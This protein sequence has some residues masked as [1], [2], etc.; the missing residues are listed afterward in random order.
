MIDAGNT[1]NVNETWRLMRGGPCPENYVDINYNDSPTDGIIM[2]MNSKFI[3]IAWKPFLCE[4]GCAVVL[5]AKA[6]KGNVAVRTKNEV[7][8]YYGH[9]SKVT[10]V[11]LCPLNENIMATCSEDKTVRIWEIPDGG[12]Q[13]DQQESKFTYKGH[14]KKTTQCE[15]HP[16]CGEVIASA[17]LDKTVHVWN[18]KTGE[19]ICNV[20]INEQPFGLSWNSNGSLL[21]ACGKQKAYVIDPR[22]GQIIATTKPFEAQANARVTFISE[23]SFI[24][25]AGNKN[26][27][28]D[29]ILYDVRQAAG[30]EIPEKSKSKKN[31]KTL[32]FSCL[33]A[34]SIFLLRS[35]RSET[36]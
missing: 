9:E 5:D 1:L 16:T 27:T 29:I 19:L 24:C 22:K 3:A 28:R 30:G 4:K 18:F 8:R 20:N 25:C 2:D 15:F 35:D 7:P 17:S 21:A 36:S 6:A 34:R 33:Y 11:K 31:E 23:N 14:T 13:Q 32:C 26:K 12:I 10:N